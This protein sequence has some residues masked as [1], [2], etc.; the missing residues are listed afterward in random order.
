MIEVFDKK[1]DRTMGSSGQ[2]TKA[3]PSGPVMMTPN[4]GLRKRATKKDF[5]E[6]REGTQAETEKVYDEPKKGRWVLRGTTEEGITTLLA[7][8]ETIHQFKTKKAAVA[9]LE[10]EYTPVE[11]ITVEVH[12]FG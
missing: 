6:Q 12:K 3:T 10:N 2:Q 4:R 1:P 11:G 7:D 9:Y 8:E 5:E